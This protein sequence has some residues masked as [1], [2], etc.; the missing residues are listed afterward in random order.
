MGVGAGL[1]AILT[2]VLKLDPR[3]IGPAGAVERTEPA[4]PGLGGPV[5]SASR[6]GATALRASGAAGV[7]PR[8]DEGKAES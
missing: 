1:Y 5:P 3:G 2:F 4:A 8:S 7:V 6:S